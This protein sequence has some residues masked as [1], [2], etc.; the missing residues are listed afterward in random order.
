MKN[1]VRL[2]RSG[3]SVVTE[4]NQGTRMDGEQQ[5]KNALRSIVRDT[6]SVSMT[7]GIAP[8]ELRGTALLNT[9]RD[10]KIRAIPSFNHAV[11]T[12]VYLPNFVERFGSEAATRIVLQFV[13]QYIGRN[14]V[15]SYNEDIFEVLYCDLMRELESPVW[16]FRGVANVRHFISDVY[17][18]EL[19]DGMTIRGRSGSDL[20]SLG[21]DAAIWD[22]ITEDWRGFGASSFVLVVEHSIAKQ[23]DNLI[24]MDYITFL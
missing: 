24:L 14:H 21:F 23:P 13:Y 11:T 4:S 8:S 16:I 20:T 9:E 7:E 19:G 12:I 17:P 10:E 1:A 5:A 22:R 18:I 6:I 15:M 3:K 2:E